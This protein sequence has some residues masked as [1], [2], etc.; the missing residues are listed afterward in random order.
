MSEHVLE[1]VFACLLE[2][3]LT[4]RT[5]MRERASV[6]ERERHSVCVFEREREKKRER[7]R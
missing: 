4:W 6:I 7:V 5:D 3:V 2:S 1:T